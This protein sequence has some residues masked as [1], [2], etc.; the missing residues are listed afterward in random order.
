MILGKGFSRTAVVMCTA[1]ACTLA[2]VLSAPAAAALAPHVATTN[3]PDTCAMCHRAHSAAG[4]FGRFDPRSWEMTASA[5]ALAVPLAAGDTALCYVCHGAEA[6]GSGTRVGASFAQRSAHSIA[7]TGSAFGP[8]VKYCSS[9]HDSHGTDKAAPGI[10]YPVLLRS[11]TSTGTPVFRNSAYCGTCHGVRP[12]S[13]FAGVAIYQQTAHFTKLPDPAIGTRVRCTICHE[14]HGSPVAPLVTTEIVPPSVPATRTVTANDRSL[15]QI[16]HSAAS[17]AYRGTAVYATSSHAV[18]ETTTTVP[19]EWP[20][21]GASRKVGECQVCHA[22]MGRNDGRGA[23][24]PTLLE[25]GHAPLCLSCHDANGPA[26]T[27]LSATLYP[28]TAASHPE[29]VAGFSAETTTAAF[30]TVAVWGTRPGAAPRTII[31]PRFYSQE[32]TA[33]A[34]A[35]GDVDADGAL[36]VVAADRGFARLTVFSY[37]PLKGLS[38]YFAPGVLVIDAIAEHL[39]VADVI[40]NT[41]KEICVVSGGTLYVYRYDAFGMPPQLLGTLPGLG[42]NVTGIA[43][44]D[45][46]GDGLDELVVT[47]AGA[48]RIHI[49]GQ[50]GTGVG[51]DRTISANVRSGVRGPSIGDVLSGGAGTGAEIA[52]ANAGEAVS[53]VSIYDGSTGGLLRDYALDVPAGARP[54]ATLVG[55]VLPSVTTTGT[56]GLELAVAA[57]GG[58][59]ASSVNVFVQTAGSALGVPQRYDTGTGAGTGSLAAGDL[60]GD[61]AA[62]L[63]VGNGGFWS[64]N[65]TLAAPPS[66]QVFQHSATL[67]SFSP[68]LTQTL[69]AGGVERAGAPPALAVADLGGVGP[70]RHPVGAVASAHAVGENPPTVRHV[71]CVDCHNAHEA[72]STVAAAPNAYGR[73]RGTSGATSAR[74]G[75]RPIVYEYELCYKCHSSYLSAAG[76]EGA[77]DISAE[78]SAANAST[79]AV[80]APGGT[81]INAGTF[82]AGWSATSRVFCVDCH[83]VS[84]AAPAVKG[85]HASSEAPIL[86]SPYLGTTPSNA[87]GLCYDCHK[88]TVY[89]TGAQDTTVT[90]GSGFWDA[91]AGALHR[92]HT[93]IHGFGCAAC[94]DSHG[95]L[96]N[97]RLIRPAITYNRLAR[98]CTGPCHPGGVTYTP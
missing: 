10:P 3:D 52:V 54:W 17:L 53:Q 56:S 65:A 36:E 6:F 18:S 68:P 11:R 63:I 94:H 37:D 88:Y 15:C 67:D 32:G 71:E 59:G 92:R 66:I 90:T 76:L 24:I 31:G 40:A 70:S 21:A 60:D 55:N 72:T 7:P 41:Q 14:G 4:D 98:S 64:R 26:R 8:S 27:D 62:E 28:T 61:G 44:G 82:E 29:L 83:S 73:I 95:V 47:D 50:W 96:G 51:I 2:V 13:R 78:L 77:E 23:P 39:V 87:D 57:H 38:S 81:T 79:H 45:L 74:I 46:D 43:A 25:A 20:A 9:C 33:G 75:I 93:A 48:S 42:A 35:V 16:C 80:V 97:A 86:R 12:A 58:S 69:R 89:Y 5:L 84:G 22:P 49:I 34:M 19:G 30:G 1:L 91:T 85:P